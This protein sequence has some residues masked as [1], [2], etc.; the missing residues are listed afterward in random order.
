[1]AETLTTVDKIY[2]TRLVGDR[3]WYREL[4][5]RS[6]GPTQQEKITRE[7]DDGF[8]RNNLQ[9]FFRVIKLLNCCT[10]LTYAS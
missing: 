4:V 3:R 1:M 2:T 5:K 6:F 9:P 7:L 10:V 8:K